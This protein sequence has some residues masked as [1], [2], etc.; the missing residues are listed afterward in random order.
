VLHHPRV[1]V[2]RGEPLAVGVV[3]LPQE[4]AI[5][6]EARIATSGSV[7]RGF[8]PT[9]G[10]SVRR[11]PRHPSMPA[12]TAGRRRGRAEPAIVAA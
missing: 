12:T 9:A 8:S 5:R 1:A 2:H 11:K 3:P 7:T 6:R 4:E 10:E